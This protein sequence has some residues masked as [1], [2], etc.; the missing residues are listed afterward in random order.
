MQGK[1]PLKGK[2]N[3]LDC[4]LDSE[5]FCAVEVGAAFFEQIVICRKHSTSN[6]F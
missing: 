2:K 6:N 5:I 4:Y 1:N 3:A